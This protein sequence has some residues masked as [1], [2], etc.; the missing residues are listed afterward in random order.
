MAKEG[1]DS[2]LETAAGDGYDSSQGCSGVEMCDDVNV[3]GRDL[4]LQIFIQVL[5]TTAVRFI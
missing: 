3:Q 2:C 1:E 5:R 4:H